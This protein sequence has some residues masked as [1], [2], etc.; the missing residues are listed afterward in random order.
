M[1]TAIAATS[2]TTPSIDVASIV[3]GLIAVESQPLTTLNKQISSYQSKISALGT[4]QS[5][6]SSFQTATQALNSTTFQS[7]TAT[8]S[9]TTALSATASTSAAAGS[10]S[11][12]VSQLAQ[13]QSLVA[14]GQ[15]VSTAPIGSG[16]STTLTFDFGTISGGTLAG[17][18]Y[19]GASFTG[20]G[21]ASKTVTID[22]TNNSLQGI[23]DAINAANIGVTATIV[24]DGSATPYRLV[25]TSNATGAASSMKISVAGDAT[26]SSLLA[27][28]PAATQNLSQT[29]AAQDA[30]LSI[31]G[32]AIT[33]SSNTVTDAIPGVTLN[34]STT[35]TSPA[36]LTVAQ[37]TTAVTNAIDKFVSAYNSVHSAISSLTSYDSTTNTAGTLQGNIVLNLIENNLTATLRSNIGSGSIS[38]L[39]QIG[40][41]F[42]KDG[43]L[44]VDKTKLDAAL[45]SNFQGV[46]DLFL[47][48]GSTTDSQ[49]KYHSATSG[50]QAGTYAVNVTQLA[51]QGNVVG[52][53]AAGLTITTGSNDTLTALVDGVSTTVTIPAGTYTATAL[54]TEVQT[55]LNTS[56]PISSIGKSVTVSQNAG[57]FTITS[58]NFGSS[59]SVTASGTAS[60][61]L[62]GAT[63]TST[64]GVDAA[65]TIDGVAA[66]GIGQYLTSS[67]GN[68]SGLSVQITGG[69]TGARGT[70][71]YS[72]G[73][74]GLLDNSLTSWL[75]STGPL[76]SETSL[77]NT[78]ITDANKQIDAL[79]VT[80]DADRKRLTDQYAKL[81]A[82]LGTMNQLSTYLTQQ[83]A[84]LP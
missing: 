34:L 31:N 75:A 25:L 2:T 69:A 4:I 39:T 66:T 68:S 43:S 78:N 45:A 77:L 35:T 62:L 6:M 65:G 83:L 59:S 76:A 42:Q 22:S 12:S 74:T 81:D 38:N 14:G 16:A 70:V 13:A 54:A 73:Y 21:S 3:S 23:R 51:T 11:V 82:M 36:T 53:A 28:D 63:P 19:S 80:L 9:N 10:Y 47:A 57:V 20:N 29:T 46:A 50:T 58:N 49:V 18:T 60:S 24:N 30:N 56:T 55:L 61:N 5:A 72:L 32:I 52:S 1:A 33:K 27:Y 44:A 41:G 71:S 67:T 40:V 84:R 8:S 26:L 64:T 79:N 37:D 7:F 17:G 48:A 15:V